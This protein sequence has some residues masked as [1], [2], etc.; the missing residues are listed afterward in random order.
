MVACNESINE[1]FLPAA[2]G[3]PEAPT[4]PLPGGVERGLPGEEEGAGV[5]E[6]P[7]TDC[8]SWDSTQVLQE[9]PRGY[10]ELTAARV[11]HVGFG[12]V[13]QWFMRVQKC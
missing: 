13:Y 12:E 8:W 2:S 3:G 5:A 7:V 4:R 1:G 9:R 10:G 6:P 11:C